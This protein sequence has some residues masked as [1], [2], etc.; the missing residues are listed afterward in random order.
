ME[1]ARET[2][3][4]PPKSPPITDEHRRSGGVH[5]HGD[6]VDDGGRGPGSGL[7][8]RPPWGCGNRTCNSV[9]WP[10]RMPAANPILWKRRIPRGRPIHLTTRREHHDEVDETHTPT[11]RDRSSCFETRFV[12]PT[13]KIPSADN[14]LPIRRSPTGPSRS[15]FPIPG[16]GARLELRWPEWPG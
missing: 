2:V 1:P 7:V 4:E 9:V 16:Q 12:R 5:A 15:S 6:A 13:R 3:N 8:R 14:M 10:I 11:P